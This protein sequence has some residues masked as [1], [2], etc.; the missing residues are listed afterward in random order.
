MPKCTKARFG[1]TTCVTGNG[2][3]THR[4]CCR[5]RLCTALDDADD[6]DIDHCVGGGSGV[7]VS[8]VVLQRQ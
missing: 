4:A 8:F 3:R 5:G 7:F 6:T 2:T 1:S